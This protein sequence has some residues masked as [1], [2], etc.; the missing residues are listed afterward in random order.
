MTK[1]VRIFFFHDGILEETDNT[2]NEGCMHL[3]VTIIDGIPVSSTLKL[4]G[5]C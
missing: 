1:Q 3:I 2:N 4:F 5:E